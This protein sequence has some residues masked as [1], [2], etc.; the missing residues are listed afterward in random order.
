LWHGHT[1]PSDAFSDLSGGRLPFVLLEA[2]PP[3]VP[4]FSLPPFH[5]EPVTLLW[6]CPISHA[7]R[8]FAEQNGS[9]ELSLRLSK[10]G[11]NNKFS[12][13]RKEVA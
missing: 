13:A 8:Q 11:G 1:L 10:L 4:Q 3:Q 7:E 5:N 12:L 2:G 6:L 9:A